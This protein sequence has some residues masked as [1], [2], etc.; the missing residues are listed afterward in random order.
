MRKSF[1]IANMARQDNLQS[2]IV[3]REK[4]FIRFNAENERSHP[5][6]DADVVTRIDNNFKHSGK[7]SE[8]S[9]HIMLYNEDGVDVDIVIENRI[10]VKYTKFTSKSIF[11]D[12]KS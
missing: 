7:N 1:S 12:C 11:A 5:Q 2:D 9:F 6:L 8:K 10:P 4:D 3:D